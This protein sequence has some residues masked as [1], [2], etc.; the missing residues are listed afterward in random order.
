MALKRT[1]PVIITCDFDPTPEIQKGAKNECMAIALDLFA[2]AGIHATLFYTATFIDQ[3]IGRLLPDVLKN[4]HEIACH[5]LTHGFEEEFDK[6]K[7]NQVRDHLTKATKLLEDF[8]GQAIRSFRGPRV[9]TSAVTQGVLESL[10]YTADASV[11]SQ[12][13]DFISSNLINF[14]WI[15]APRLPYH[16]HPKD[17]YRSGNRRLWVVPV[18]AI[19]LPFVS[20]TIYTFGVNYAKFLF[21]LLYRESLKTGKPIMFLLHPAEFVPGTEK[22]EH[23]FHLK[24]LFIEGFRFRRAPWLFE[25]DAAKRIEGNRR[26]YAYMRSFP[27]VEFVTLKNYVQ[28]LESVQKKHDTSV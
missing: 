1:V 5:G 3:Y 28:R 17:A 13:V 14:G 15:R 26:L 12:R 18:S 4:G 25:Q 19:V 22:V 6:M 8:S 9:K 10:G 2:E 20:G 27:F 11:C 21:Q 16:P 24:N 7:E 23:P